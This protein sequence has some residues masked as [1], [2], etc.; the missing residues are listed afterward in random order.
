MN[1]RGLIEE[2]GGTILW[3]IIIIALLFAAS[4]AFGIIM[5]SS[6]ESQANSVLERFS[7]FLSDIDEGKSSSFVIYSPKGFYFVPSGMLVCICDKSV[8][9]GGKKKWCKNTDRPMEYL[10]EPIMINI[11]TFIVTKTKD[12]YLL[13]ADII[14]DS[15][16]ESVEITGN[17]SGEFV[18]IEQGFKGFELRNSTKQIFDRAVEIAKLNNVQLTIISAYRT[19]VQ[20]EALW[21][22]YGKDPLRVCNPAPGKGICPH[23]TGCAVD[24]CLGDLCTKGNK[25][26]DL[27]NEETRLL[28]KIMTEAGFVRYQYEYWHFEYGTTRWQTCKAQETV[29]C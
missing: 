15:K 24:V 6:E 25:P 7:N 22:K 3:I 16:E 21:I 29:V 4:R 18:E 14:E 9:E 8:C 20:Q 28:Q 17:C 1:K 11:G 27:N 5:T 13:N 26:M 19:E 12:K 23:Q 10:G 2:F